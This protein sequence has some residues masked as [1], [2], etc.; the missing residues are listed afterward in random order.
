[1]SGARDPKGYYSCLGVPP[2]ASSEDIKSA[3][4]RFAKKIHPDISRDPNA[5]SQFQKISEAYRILSDPDA[6]RAYDAIQYSTPDTDPA[7]EQLDPIRCSHCGKVTAQPRSTIFYRVVSVVFMTMK[8]PIQ[9]TFCS[10][11]ATKLGLTA[12]LVSGLFGWWGFP[13]GPIWTISSICTNAAGGRHSQEIDEKLTWYNA[14]AF[15]SQG[16]LAISNALAQQSLRARNSEVSAGA[17]KLIDHLRQLGVPA[18]SPSLKN[19][20]SNPAVAIAH[21]ALLLLVPGAIGLAVAYDDLTR[22]SRQTYSR[23][24]TPPIRQNYAP[25][26][27][28]MTKPDFSKYA[29]ATPA[30]YQTAPSVPI[31]ANPPRNGQILTQNIFLNNKGHVVEIRNG[32][33]ANAIVKLRDAYT[34]AVKLSFF[35]ERGNTVSISNLP[36]SV[37]RIQYGFGGDLGSDCRSFVRVLSAS[38][39]PEIESLTTQYTATEIIRKRLSYTLYSVPGGNVRPQTL[40]LAAFNAD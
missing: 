10:S 2:S 37:Y 8:T 17:K 29:T 21:V 35:V 6:R 36:D 9:G 3:Y 32:S 28:S 11:C 15:L 39:F 24:Y 22:S 1:M 34:N 30:P 19:P 7:P 20:W 38:Q 14:L 5:N 31:C 40:D 16:K 4:R 13:W 33:T 12:S 18:T 23:N 27:Q 26:P 25:P